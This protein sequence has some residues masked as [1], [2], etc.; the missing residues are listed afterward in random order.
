M[1]GYFSGFDTLPEVTL[2][3]RGGS[4]CFVGS[5][6]Y[7]ATS[8]NFDAFQWYENGQP[9]PGA[10]GPSY[11][12]TGAG[13]FFLRGTK[14]PCTYDSNAIQALYCDPDVFVQKTVDQTEIMEGETATFTIRV[15][16]L[17]VGPLTNLQ[18]TDNIPAGLTLVNAFTIS[19]SF[20]GNLWNIGTLD[21]GD[22]AF[23]E[24]EVRADEIDTLPLVSLTNTVTNTQD[25]TDTNITE[26]S[27]SATLVVHNDYDNDGVR[28]VT[29]L[30]DD[31][32]GVYDSEEC[33][34]LAFNI[35]GGASHSSTLLSVNN[36]MVLDIFSLDNSF[37]LEINGTDLAGEIQFQNAAGNFARFL[38]GNGYGENGNPQIYTLT[39]SPGT[40]LLRVIVNELGELELFG[41]RTS[42]GPLEPMVL[43]TPPTAFTWNPGG[44]NLVIGQAVVGPTNMQGVLLTAGC[45]TDADGIPDQ[46]DLDSD[47][48]GCT[49]AVE[50]YKDN[51]AD[52][53]DGG[54]Y[55]S[56]V[57]VVDPADG[58]VNAASYVRVLA[59]EI[60]LGNTSEDLGGT[61]INGQGVSLGQTYNYVL[62]F[63]NTGDDNAV[64]YSIRD[65]LPNNVTLE[66]I[67]ISNAPGTTHNY[68][69]NTQTITFEIPDN[70]VEVGDPEYS[71]RITVRLSG[72]CSDFVNA[73][74]SELE[75]RAYSTFEGATNNTVFTDE[76]GS[77]NF[78]CE[79]TPETASNNILDDLANCDQ[80][81]TVQ[82][83]GDDVVLF[84]GTGFTSYTWAIDNNNNGQIDA[85]D[86]VLNDG[87]PDNDPSTLL[88]TDIGN[89]IVEKSNGGGCP[90]QTE[91]I[92]VERFGT[93]QT[94]PIIDYFNQV[95]SD[96][97]PDNDMQGEI[98]TCSIDGDLLPKIFLCGEN[99]EALIQLGITDATS[100]V[101]ERLDEASCAD[102]GDDCANKNTACAWTNLATQ[103]NYTLTESGEYRVVINYQNGCFS[104]FYFNVFKNNL[105][106]DY[107]SDDILCNTP[108]NIRV[109]NIGAGYGFQL[110]DVSTAA[111]VVPFSANNGPNFDIATSGTYVVQVTQLDPITGDPI[112]GSCLFETDDIGIL[113]RDFQVN[114]ST[115]PADC[116]QLGSVTVQAL[117]VLPNYS[118]E[119]RLDDGANAGQGTLVAQEVATTDNTHTFQNVNPGDYLIVTTTQ[120][121]CADTQP[122]TVDEIPTLTLSAV[123]SENI[124]CSAGVVLLTPGGGLPSPDYRMAIWSKDGVPL[125]ADAASVPDAAKQTATSFLFGY[126]GTPAT[127]FPNEDGDYQ[128][129]VFD[130]N[131]CSSLSNIVTVEDLGGVSV[132]A[133]HSAI[134]CADSSSSTLTITASGG[135][136]PY[137]YSLDGGTTYQSSNT[138]V[139][140]A[141]GFYTI[142]VMDSSG[143]ACVE[144]IDYE[145][146]QPFPLNASPSIIE[147]ASCNPAGARVKIRNATGG[148]APYEYSFDGGSNF[149]SNDERLLLPGNYQLQVRDALGCVHSMDLQVPTP[150]ADPN[151]S[152][153]IDYNCDGTATLTLNTSN[154]SDFDYTYALDGT[155]NTPADSNVFANL[156]AGT[157][158]VTVGYSSALSPN[159]ST[160]FFEDFGSGPTTQIAEVGADYCFE[161]QD[162]STTNC[163]R[164]PA[165]ILV[166]GEYT[167]TSF[168]TNPVPSWLSPQD[169]SGLAGGRFLAIDVSTFSDTGAPVLNSVLWARRDLEVLPNE[170]IMLNFWAYNLMQVGN[171]GNNP[172]VLVEIL[173]NTGTVIHSEVAPAIP[174]NNND[175][176]W[177]E[178]TITFNPGANT[179]IDIVL[180]SNVNSNDGNDLVL[181][182]ITAFQTAEVCARTQDL[183]VVIEADQAFDAQ[184]LNTNDP[185]CNGGS[186][187]SIRFEVS[188][189]TTGVGYE[190]SLDGGTNWTSSLNASETTAATLGAG[191]YTVL[192]RKLDELSCTASFDATLS[193]P[194]AVV[195]SLNLIADYTCFN[196]GA[197]L[198][199]AAS[200]GTAGYE[201]QLEDTTTAVV[202]P[203]QTATLFNNVPDGSY[204]LRVRDSRNCEVATS[205]AVVVTAPQTVDFD[206]T[207]TTCYDGQNNAQI[208]ASVNTGNGGYT[209]RING[210]AWLTPTPAT[211]TTYTFAGLSDG[212]YTVEV[213][214]SFGCVSTPENIT[215]N[216]MLQGQLAIQ[217]I[218][219]CG[220]GSITVTASGGDTNYSYAFLPTGTAVQDTDFGAAN[221]YTVTSGNAGDYDVYIR[222]NGG[223]APYCQY[224]ETVT[225]ATAPA[226]AF[227]TTPEDAECFGETGNIAVNITSGEG[228]FTYELVD[229]DNAISDQT[230]TGV[231][232]T[233]RTYFNLLPGQYDVIITD[234]HGCV[235][236][237]SGIVVS[238]PAE[239][240]ADIGG[241][242][243]GNCTGD[244]NDFGLN[245]TNYPL[246]PGGTIEFSADGGATWTGD[247]SIPGTTDELTGYVSGSTVNPSMRT[248]DG[249]GNTVCQTDFPPFVIPF[250]LDDLDITILPIIVNCNEL[251]VS[252]RGSN[253]TAPYEYTYTDDPANFDQVTPVNGWTAP[254]AAGVT[255]TFTG[256]VPGRTYSFYVRD[257]VGCVRQSSV[258]V[259]DIV[260]NPME[261]DA[262]FEPS[263]N[264]SNDG[265]ITYTITDTDGSTEPDMR[266]TLYDIDDNPITSSGGDVPYSGTIAVTGL[267]PDEYYVVVEQVNG[268]VVQCTSASENLLLQELDPI[269]ATLTKIQ[270]I[271]CENPGIISIDNIQG[272]G[273]TYTF[274]VTGPAPFTS[275][276]GTADNPVEIPANSPAGNYD[277]TISDQFGCSTPLGSIAMDLSPNPTID[278]IAIDNCSASN[279]VSITASSTS[280]TI[281]YSL[282]GGTTYLDN[283]GS[284]TNVA[285][286]TYTVMVRDGFGCT[287]SQ[288]IDVQPSLQATAG[289]TAT[290]GC[291]VGNEAEIRLEVTS[292]SG[293]Y[294]FEVIG[295]LGTLVARQAL[296]ATTH[297]ISVNAADTYTVTIFDTATSGPECSRSFSLE[298]P[299]AIVPDFSVNPSD[300]S[301]FGAADGNIAI[302]EVNNGNNP[303]SY[304]LTPNN[305]SYNAAT[306]TFENLPGGTYQV[307]GTGP[308]GCSTTISNIQVNEPAAITFAMPAVTPFGCTAGNTTVNATIAWDVSSIAGG[309][310]NY[311]RFVFVDNATSTVLQ[312]GAATTYTHTDFAGGNILVR[313]FDDMGCTEFTIVNIPP[314][315]QLQS[316][317]VQV[318][319]PISCVNAGE[320]ISIDVTGSLSTYAGNPGNYEF[321]QLPATT[322]QATNQFTD[323]APGTYT[324]GVRNVN[325]GCEILVEHVVAEP[326][327]FDVIV[328]KLA[329]AVCFGDDGS[330]QLTLVD[331]T[332]AAGFTWSIYATNG[333]PADRS[334]DGAAILTG[335]SV[336]AGPTPA[337]AVAAGDYLVE[338]TQDAFP[339]CSQVRFFSIS[340]P[341]APLTLAPIDL[342]QVGCSN[343]QGSAAITPQGG[344]APYDISLTHTGTGNVTV[345]SQVTGHIFQGL[346]AGQYDLSVTD[347]LGCT[348]HYNNAFELLL[349]DPISGTISN[350]TLLCEGDVD[351][352]VSLVLNPR[353]V[354]STY[355][356]I[357]NQYSDATGTTVLET[358]AAQTA[359][360]FPNLGAGFYAITVLDDMGC[361]FES[362]IVEIPDPAEVNAQLITTQT[363]SCQ[364][365][366]ELELRAMGGTAPYTWSADGVSFTAM[367]AAAGPDTHVFTNVG[368]GSYQYYIRDSFN[369]ISV[370]SNE[371]TINPVAPLVLD[372]DSS[373]A[374]VNCSGDST[375]VI[376]AAADGGLGNY[377]YAL[378][379]DAALTAEIRPNQ[380]SGTFAD[381]PQGTYFVRVQ[382]E[383]CETVSAAIAV[384]E[385]TPL[386]VQ[387]AITDISCAGARDGSITLDVQGG[388]G[389]YQF[390]ISPNLNQFVDE[391][392]FDELAPGNYT[393]IAQDALGCFEVIDFTITEPAELTLNTTVLDEICFESSDGV[394]NLEINGGTA[395]YSSALNSNSDT[396]FTQDIIEYNNLPSG[397]HVVF[398]RDANGCEVSA[399]FEVGSG[400]NLAGEVLMEYPC[401]MGIATNSVSLAFEDDTILGDVLY[402]L[403]T[404]DPNEMV[405]D[406]TFENLSGGDH[407]ITVIHSNGCENTFTF[408][409]IDFE[410]VT[411]ELTEPGINTIQAIAAGGTGNYTYSFNGVDNGDDPEYYITETDTYSVTVTD[412]NGCTVTQEIFMEFIDIEI[413][414][415]FTPDGDGNNDV[416][417]PNNIEPYP[418]IYIVIFDRYGRELYKF[419]GNQDGWDG[420]YQLTDLPSGDYWYII[421]LNGEADTREF[422]G[423]FTLYR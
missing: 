73:C 296:P 401:E 387:P 218:S 57:P 144:T 13:E 268:G 350:T 208:T 234:S 58:T 80:A 39:G 360:T 414:N 398:V 111:I 107:T 386:V 97:N 86:T 23:L 61:D 356:F 70:L 291:G 209:F 119:L 152:S 292:G 161:P 211:A 217:D 179:D 390:A 195:P 110:V 219:S 305:G 297:N 62:R 400:V 402:G 393:V 346:S 117:N 63:Q 40:P 212:T 46:L 220:D 102:S 377:Q 376:I 169:H 301:C 16:N 344:Q 171:A 164:G 277:V 54:E 101:W 235:V 65:I 290:L 419:S 352:T 198:E 109:T 416:W 122:I 9:I 405:M 359:A 265:E 91:L 108:G 112:P 388:T 34:G 408:E 237:D 191:T 139:N 384:D 14:G 44:N 319:D 151:L 249:L 3:I 412:E 140:M 142:T 228:P 391:N 183:N 361:S 392:L 316:A 189:F 299:P 12:P 397:T 270:D 330:I 411:L 194:T 5:E 170:E 271:S 129:I 331:A 227:T 105:D 147:D 60:L 90:D 197:T 222:D 318:D 125:Y 264:G 364:L 146:D 123:T 337:I 216:P 341:D 283:G 137:Q 35:S 193:E 239:L 175:N 8:N 36:Y 22:T 95:N 342:T 322:Y 317:A 421:K 75:N 45:D 240:T 59:P 298:I 410:P 332:Y 98:V 225:V 83:C 120:D 159:Q 395:P 340:T 260:T 11:A 26:D 19:G 266:W 133:S 41:S 304:A 190:Y 333:T 92:T 187:G 334:D 242:T 288:S 251:Q 368:D 196:T 134:V 106:I 99:D 72:N 278:A 131:G 2:E 259:N 418:N 253:G 93:T 10:N 141:A 21:G 345:I 186:D 172:E 229:I 238:Q 76:P 247:N 150:V 362:T 96:S 148:Q 56:G 226:L 373:S 272:G 182:D 64:N 339:D 168:V 47:G 1:A 48:D 372:I 255:H 53:G 394:V 31:N 173:D 281:L 321:R 17:G 294:D 370:I 374:I 232:A 205:T 358:T 66:N 423:H 329:D 274:T 124:T 165:G 415:Y 89:Y 273:G 313:V 136:A 409:I 285:A 145:I 417:R 381:L 343:D 180:R 24:L 206:L 126:R 399:V 310:G 295:T 367:N 155:A 188:N 267:A 103:D 207:A 203:F 258:N 114:L 312:D 6:L 221:A 311:V 15:Q 233:T 68:D 174:K 314:Y 413:P 214:D 276:V 166:N 236:T 163:N 79:V 28:D 87:D 325:T 308:N 116:N 121:G 127:Y 379:A 42:N 113:E 383:D 336:N 262:A 396:D 269:S 378:F 143:T 338:V 385:P 94:N 55:G 33:S 84:A 326:N 201:Y 78:P 309:S 248:V 223:T 138:F 215:I 67:D 231:V 328:D 160:L 49:D 250:P 4:G 348:E 167:V 300:T 50:F 25:Q 178:R 256:L 257:A 354:P 349:P 85:A 210:G 224:T 130:G 403:D 303:L 185:N 380:A 254:V 74:A 176:D 407:Y 382:S 289:V 27:P 275:L 404:T 115:T 230:Q 100:I 293:S 246:L 302:T 184:L 252:V 82:L 422:V 37:S 88:V 406:G 149:D 199:A 287:A 306:Q 156:S 18:I 158:T 280:P 323:L 204:I 77:S 420:Q 279:T 324:F 118:Y 128:F 213:S 366:A 20:S 389:P 371:I 282:D 244:I 200:G 355:R 43:T 284:F 181:D 177:H 335:N 192:V 241:V 157:Y 375:A 320:D 153:D 263:C 357:L 51:T 38:D 202:R 261:I 351:A 347:A 315:D 7:E 353:N 286:G 369:C 69:A 243:P 363:L 71:I 307:V 81:R 154:A 135:N 132:S 327:T 32:D 245:F 30:D 104:R 162:G 52:G 365:G 29:D